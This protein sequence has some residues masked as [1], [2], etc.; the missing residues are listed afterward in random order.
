MRISLLF[1]I[2]I[3][4]GVSGLPGQTHAGS[5]AFEVASIKP[6]NPQGGPME[7]NGLHTYPGG[8]IVCRG[9]TLEYLMEQAFDIQAFQLSGGPGWMNVDRF[10]IE[11][12]PPASSLSSKANPLSSKAAP[13]AEQRQMLE[14]LLADRFQMAVRREV[15]QGPVYVLMKGSRPLR[16]EAAKDQGK[17]DFSWVGSPKGG[18]ITG[19]GMAGENISMPILAARLSRYL[20]RPVLDQ[21]GIAG[22]FDFKFDYATDE[23]H[24]DVVSAILA[25]VQG[26]GLKLESGKG[27]VETIVIDHAERPSAN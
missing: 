4:G 19:D 10:E 25:S 3:A 2:M 13:N 6:S 9:C 20:E 22:F 15:K 21:T 12:R 24:P 7:I 18:M 26:I 27:P 5:P 11:A 23:P 1:A 16:L 17:S 8:R 14:T